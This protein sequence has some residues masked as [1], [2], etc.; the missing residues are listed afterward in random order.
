[1]QQLPT[2]KVYL[3]NEIPEEYQHTMTSF[4]NIASQENIMR[5]VGQIGDDW[6]GSSQAKCH[7]KSSSKTS[8]DSQIQLIVVDDA[9]DDEQH[10]FDIGLSTTLKKLFN[11]YAEKRGVSLRSLRFSYDGK[12][13][14]LSSVGN[15]S[16][17]ELNMRDLDVITVTVHNTNAGQEKTRQ[18]NQTTSKNAKKSKN[19]PKRTKG[20][21]K[22]RQTK[23]RQEEPV[24]IKTLNEYKAQH[25][26]TLE[27]VGKQASHILSF[28]LAKCKICTR[29]PS[30]LPR[31][32]II[33]HAPCPR[34]ICIAAQ[35][36]KHLSNLMKVSKYG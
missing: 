8:D 31:R 25:S 26:R 33:I 1:M 13:L 36:R 19:S 9:N 6:G 16:P 34:W 23:Q 4:V 32:H 22:K 15:K 27:L 11:D 24:K 7:H 17:N 29:R 30:H 28:R 18:A 12:T 10:S 2:M 3:E 21:G 5:Y 20:K 14:F 35:G